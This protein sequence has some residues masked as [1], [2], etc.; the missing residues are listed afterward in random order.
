MSF[1]YTNYLGLKF[2]SF[3][4]SKNLNKKLF[5]KLLLFFGYLFLLLEVVGL[6]LAAY[7]LIKETFPDADYFE[8]LNDYV[9]IFLL[10]SFSFIFMI[11]YFKPEDIKPFML[12]PVS[13]K[14]ILAFYLLNTLLS[15][16]F[17]IFGLWIVTVVTVYALWGYPLAGLLRW[18][19][20]LF[21][22]L[23]LINVFAW[24]S[25]RS[26]F[27]G[28]LAPVVMIG[29]MATIEKAPHWFKPV[30]KFYF[31]IYQGQYLFSGILLVLGLSVIYLLYRNLLRKF[32]LDGKI[33]TGTATHRWSGL[34][35]FAAKYGITGAFIQNDLRL[36]LRNTRTKMVL[37]SSL[38]FILFAAFVFFS[39]Y[40][41]NNTFMHVFTA[42]M[43]TAGF[44]M[45]FGSFVPAWD[46]AYFKLLMSQGIRYRDYLEAK[47]WLLFVSVIVLTVLSLPFLYFGP[48]I[49][50]MI[51]AFAVFNAGMNIYFILFTGLLNTTPI[52]LNEKV[53]AFSGGQ[54]FNGKIFILTLIRLALPMGLYF[55]LKALWNENVALSVIALTGL[56]GF[57]LKGLFIEYLAGLYNKRKYMMIE[58]YASQEE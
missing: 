18:G 10:V 57:A 51:L 58:S 41:K 17:I 22:S 46:S 7:F 50:K 29:A 11:N 48:E 47:W 54:S 36:I 12:L 39:P 32:Y 53:S 49:F 19:A 3:W 38:F 5:V 25:E 23:F 1:S 14:R 28:M 30:S 52:R 42:V 15:P 33:K 20:A 44:L 31:A 4:R 24:M 37:Q 45:N 6:G 55:G 40:Y 2:K 8:K 21:F 35:D 9:Y 56:A 13:K 27:V 26:T 34:I 43:L 16:A